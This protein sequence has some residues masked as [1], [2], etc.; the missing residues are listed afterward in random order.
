MYEEDLL[1]HAGDLQEAHREL[2]QS[3]R[4]DKNIQRCLELLSMG[5]PSH[6]IRLAETSSSMTGFKNIFVPLYVIV[7]D[8]IITIEE[9]SCVPKKL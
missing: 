6:C 4:E 2:H 1:V 8:G 9:T 7:W 3:K 5:G